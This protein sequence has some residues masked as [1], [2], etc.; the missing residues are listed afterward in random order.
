MSDDY[1]DIDPGPDETDADLLDEDRVELLHCPHCG[2]LIAEDTPQCPHCKLWVTDRPH[3]A[4]AAKPWWWVVL[5]ALGAAG[6][7][8]LYAL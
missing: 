5:A 7:L 8:L 6:F 3:S 2:E 4:F 1:D